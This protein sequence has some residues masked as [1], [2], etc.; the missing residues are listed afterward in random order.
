MPQ[1]SSAIQGAKEQLDIGFD[2]S[3]GKMEDTW[4]QSFSITNDKVLVDAL[5]L[6]TFDLSKTK[7]QYLS[8]PPLLEKANQSPAVLQQ[9]RVSNTIIEVSSD[10]SKLQDIGAIK[11]SNLDTPVTNNSPLNGN[12]RNRKTLPKSHLLAENTSCELGDLAWLHTSL[13]NALHTSTTVLNMQSD[14]LDLQ[15]DLMNVMATHIADINQKLDMLTIW[16]PV[17]KANVDH[18]QDP[19]KCGQIINKLSTLP[20]M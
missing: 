8:L 10:M 13:L 20:N 19:C 18:L 4:L 5:D 7:E 9:E 16:P 2:A 11:F 12:N 14:K 3:T 15:S 17:P 1:S 6:K